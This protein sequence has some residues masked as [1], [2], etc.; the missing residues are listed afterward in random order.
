MSLDILNVEYL[1][2]KLNDNGV[3]GFFVEI[4]ILEIGKELE[5]PLILEQ[6]TKG[7][8][9]QSDETKEGCNY[10]NKCV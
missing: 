10:V 1:I 4:E 2:N 9:A 8:N 5:F 7:P 3:R 6:R